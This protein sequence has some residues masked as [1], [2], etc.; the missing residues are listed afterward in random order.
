MEPTEPMHLTAR[1]HTHTHTHTHTHRHT[2]T[3]TNTHT[4]THTDNLPCP[5]ACSSIP[6]TSYQFERK[7]IVITTCMRFEFPELIFP[8]FP[9]YAHLHVCTC[10]CTHSSVQN[11]RHTHT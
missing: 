1:A 8:H 11:N 7:I 2:H 3:H 4:H 10:V 5:H 6:L 9:S